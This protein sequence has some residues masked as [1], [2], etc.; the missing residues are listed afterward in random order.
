MRDAMTETETATRPTRRVSEHA[1]CRTAPALRVT[2]AERAV[3][4][5]EDHRTTRPLRWLASTPTH[6]RL[7]TAPCPFL[8][9]GRFCAIYA[10]RPEA[11]R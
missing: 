6:A 7:A 11:C 10:W 3:L 5:R 4:E 9:D 8:H 2:S 1:R